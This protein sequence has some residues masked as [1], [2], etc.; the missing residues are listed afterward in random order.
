MKTKPPPESWLFDVEKA[1]LFA[2]VTREG[3]TE[4]V[5]AYRRSALIASDTGEVVGIV[6]NDYEL[7]TN[8]E[9]IDLCMRFCLEAFPDTK[10]AEWVYR[11]AHGPESRSWVAMDIFHRSSAV[12]LPGTGDWTSEMFTPYVRITNSYNASRAVRLD[13]GFMRGM[14]SNGVIF[15][16]AVAKLLAAHT[17]AGIRRLK[18]S[19]PFKGMAALREQFGDTLAAVRAVAA[20]QAEGK[21]M[22]KRV[23]GWPQLPDDAKPRQRIDQQMLEDDLEIRTRR[24]FHELGEN[25]YAAFNVMTDIASHPPQNP[26]FRRDRPSMERMAGAWLR[27]FNVAAASPGFTI[28]GHLKK[29]GEAQPAAERSGV[30]WRN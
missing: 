23:I 12:N 19:Q 22:T 14:C 29:L 1:P 15:A 3:G 4:Y 8:Q 20:T 6:G 5:P 25:A 28:Q 16:E 13:V 17:D 27:D 21:E 30:R 10:A 9:A 7:F 11:D 24:Y 18:F 2:S 26:R